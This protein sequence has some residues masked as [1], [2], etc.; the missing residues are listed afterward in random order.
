MLSPG[1]INTKKF[2]KS[3]FGYRVDDVD[4]YLT[5]VAED[6]AKLLHDNNE[7]ENKMVVLA[8]RLEEY[9]KE[10]NSLSAALLGAQK[11]SDSLLREAKEKAEQIINEANLKAQR[12]VEAAQK[13]VLF[14]R[15]E[16]VRVQREIGIFK[17][18]LLSMYKSQ[19]DLI[20]ALPEGNRARPE[21]EAPATREEKPARFVYDDVQEVEEVKAVE[22]PQPV[23]AFESAQPAAAPVEPVKQTPIEPVQEAAQPQLAPKQPTAA[24]KGFVPNLADDDISTADYHNTYQGYAQ[25]AAKPPVSSSSIKFE[26][27]EN[28]E[29]PLTTEPATS[30]FGELKFGAAYDLKRDNS[31]GGNK[32]FRK[33]R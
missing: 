9:R 8:D 24:G 5:A 4:T 28:E 11:M 1:D 29:V 17:S 13:Q 31:F 7:L 20:R 18:N 16:L 19:M 3:A 25:K 22:Q 10:E 27:E 12:I 26:K 6:Y 32:S 23:I 15:N 2:E 30:R 21:Q 14:E 33:K